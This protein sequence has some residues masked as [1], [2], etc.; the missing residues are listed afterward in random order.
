MCEKTC[1]KCRGPEGGK[2]CRIK[3]TQ[4]RK[5][6]CS[7]AANKGK[8]CP[9]Y[10][11]FYEKYE[12]EKLCDLPKCACMYTLLHMY[13]LSIQRRPFFL[14]ANILYFQAFFGLNHYKKPVFMF[15]RNYKE[16]LPWEGFGHYNLL[17]D[18]DHRQKEDKVE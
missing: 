3:A 15:M 17:K 18:T 14:R 16:I 8:T 12:E 4:S 10:I 9:N 7:A 2:G 11:N 13:S 1:Y 6:S 5:R